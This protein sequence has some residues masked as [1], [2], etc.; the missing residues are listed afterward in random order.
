MTAA[1]SSFTS[2]ATGPAAVLNTAA[3]GIRR[4][5]ANLS[6]ASTGLAMAIGKGARTIY[7]MEDVLNEI[8]GRRFGKNDTFTLASGIEMSRQQFRDSVVALVNEINQQTPRT[9]DEIM[10]AYNQLVQAG[11]SHEQVQAILPTSMDFAI[12]G[13]FDTEEAADKLTNVMT[14]MRL[15]MSTQRQAEESAKRA[16]DVI[17]YAATSTNSS[18][19]QMTEAFKY[20]APSASALGVSIEQLAAMF[21]IQARRGIKASEAGVSIRAMLTRMVRSTNMAQASLARYNIDL[22]DYLEATKEITAADFSTAMSF[23]GLDARPAE[24]AIDKILGMDL[25]SSEKV[26]LITGA[27]MNAV[28]DKTTM[29]AQSISD[30]VTETLFGFGESLDVERL[31]ADMQKA[32]IAM[33]DFFKI[34]DVRQGARTLALFG[35]DLSKWVDDL[36]ENSAGFADALKRTRMQGIVG[37]WSQLSAALVIGAQK[38]ASSG[39]LEGA[40]RLVERLRDLTLNI[41]EANPQ[42]LKFGTYAVIGLAALAPLGFAITGIAAALGL[43]VNPLALVVAGL[44]T[45][46]ILKWDA[47]SKFAENFGRNFVANLDPAII[48]RF[49]SFV[50]KMKEFGSAVFQS[51]SYNMRWAKAS[52]AWGKS[53]AEAL[54]SVYN[55]M[56]KFLANDVVQSFIG[57]MGSLFDMIGSAGSLAGRTLKELGDAAVAF[58]SSFMEHLSPGASDAI[59]S[60]LKNMLD[61]ISNAYGRIA[62]YLDT[63]NFDLDGV[64]AKAG[65]WAAKI[66]NAL[67][68]IGDIDLYGAGQKIMQSLVDGLLSVFQKLM[69]VVSSIK[70]ALTINGSVNVSGHATMSAREAQTASERAL[71][72]AQS[73]GSLGDALDGRRAAGGPVR[74]GLSYLVGEGGEPEIFTPGANGFITPMSRAGGGGPLIGSVHI[75]GANAD[76]VMAKLN[77][78][79]NQT[80]MRSRQLAMD[81]RPVYE[82]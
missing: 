36:E 28:G 63:I 69:S 67:T 55:G 61:G 81:G 75:H 56:Q 78:L 59:A 76:E 13:N 6:V 12:A 8:E 39:V 44:S 15:P 72:R 40:T 50:D 38:I 74:R 9:A 18:V 20:A 2:M 37:A 19:E 11:L 65:E 23:A 49:S 66:V 30:A 82:W 21:L 54:N 48:A 53:T 32:G 35:D 34:F 77:N 68:S 41:A 43:M 7:S 42:L 26:K 79:L 47:I 51:S 14:A 46:A 64:G 25:A 70:S 58:G 4:N 5:V 16:A 3:N 22:A 33:S 71:I 10:K 60:G 62:G 27:I 17:A 24:G 45:I 29:S 73:D 57:A 52:V 31:I 80:L 1:V